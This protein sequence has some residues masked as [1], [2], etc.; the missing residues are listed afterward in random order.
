M[1]FDKE[2]FHTEERIENF[3][4][5]WKTYFENGGQQLPLSVV[6]QEELLDA[7]VHPENHRDLIVRVGGYS[8]H[9]TE[10]S[11][12]L[13]DNVIAHTSYCC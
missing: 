6:S 7:E 1:K 4:A 12:R 5:L 3:I 8:V 13:Q 10:R 2:I 9:F 11:V